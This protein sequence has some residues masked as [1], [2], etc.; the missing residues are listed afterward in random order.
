V[1]FC[2]NYF[3]IIIFL[4]FLITSVDFCKF[5]DIQICVRVLAFLYVFVTV[6]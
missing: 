4:I 6:V 5:V 3:L 2:G 1:S